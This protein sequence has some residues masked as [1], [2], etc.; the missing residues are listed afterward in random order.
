MIHE[1]HKCQN[2]FLSLLTDTFNTSLRN[3][4][5][6]SSVKILSIDRHVYQLVIKQRQR[7]SFLPVPRKHR[8]LLPGL[9]LTSHKI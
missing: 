2:M 4:G 8:Y 3:S 1:F 5:H 6:L 7:A 9:A